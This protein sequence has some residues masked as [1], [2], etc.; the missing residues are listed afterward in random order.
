MAWVLALALW[1]LLGVVAWVHAQL[2]GL[3]ARQLIVTYWEWSV[4][5]LL[6]PFLATIGT[7]IPG[8]NRR[9]P[10]TPARP[11]LIS[12]GYVIALVIFSLDLLVRAL[13]GLGW[14]PFFLG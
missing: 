11:A 13:F 7:T 8:P 6:L 3:P 14:E 12:M 10:D 2:A 4:A 9:G 5:L 1:A